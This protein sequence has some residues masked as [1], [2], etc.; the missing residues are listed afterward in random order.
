VHARVHDG[1]GVSHP[2]ILDHYRRLTEGL[3]GRFVEVEGDNVPQILADQATAREASTMVLSRH[4]SAFTEA[5][6]GSVPR[7]LSRLKPELSV[8]EVRKAPLTI[9][10]E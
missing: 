4:H 5:L 1:S 10:G 9:S 6:R 8:V 3:G 7:R 2:E